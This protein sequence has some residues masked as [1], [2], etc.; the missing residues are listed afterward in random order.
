MTTEPA[1]FFKNSLEPFVTEWVTCSPVKLLT[2]DSIGKTTKVMTPFYSRPDGIYSFVLMVEEKRYFYQFYSKLHG[3]TKI[4]NKQPAKKL[5]PKEQTYL[6]LEETMKTLSRYREPLNEF[7]ILDLDERLSDLTR[8]P[9]F[10]DFVPRLFYLCLLERIAGNPLLSLVKPGSRDTEIKQCTIK[11]V[12][13]PAHN[14]LELVM[15]NEQKRLTVFFLTQTQKSGLGEERK[16]GVYINMDKYYGKGQS[17][18]LLILEI[19][20]RIASLSEDQLET[21]SLAKMIYEQFVTN[22]VLATEDL[23]KLSMN[24]MTPMKVDVY[25]AV[26][27]FQLVFK[28]ASVETN[29]NEVVSLLENLKAGYSEVEEG[30]RARLIIKT[31]RNM[32]QDYLELGL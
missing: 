27:L 18:P 22:P 9:I 13:G 1:A 20:A 5:L 11:P 31:L 6:Y 17:I 8:K 25:W 16:K 3:Y 2:P 19:V 26:K 29:A 4:I 12:Y 15:G 32:I 14:P 21:E 10:P 23:V 7:T 24:R 30:E 28:K